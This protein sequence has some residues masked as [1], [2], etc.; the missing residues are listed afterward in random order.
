M[1][2]R[3]S[4]LRLLGRTPVRQ[5]GQR[6]HRGPATHVIILDGT[7]STLEP[8]CE[9]NAGLLYK[10]LDEIG[11]TAN[12]TVYYEAGLQWRNWG[13]TP[14]VAMGRGLNQQIR[15]AY[16]VLASRYREGDKII[17]AGYSRGAFAVRSLAGIIDTVGL[18]RDTDANV[19]NIRT[20]YQHYRQGG[21]S[22]AADAFRRRFCHWSVE[23]EAV[24]VWET[25]KALGVRLPI[26]WR[27]AEPAHAFHNHA[28]GR[29]IRHGFHALA[30]D[31]TREAY[32][33]V[34]WTARPGSTVEQVW[35]RGNHSDVGGQL[36]GRER[37]RPLSNIPLVWM[38]ER[39]ESCGV[40]LPEGWVARFPCDVTAPS[41]GSWT[42][43]GR[44]FLMR[45]KRLV[46]SDPSE[47]VHV[48][49][50]VDAPAA[51]VTGT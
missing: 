31:E 48:T 23:I 15:R 19:R 1:G 7:L 24:A 13:E 8:G 50:R 40:P 32:A 34:L 26:L 3:S 16:G 27:W 2:L 17:L 4:L 9:T 11:R 37:C 25:V 5:E 30:L 49:A 20:A 18:I 21:T 22:A 38:L 29:S 43:W 14:A 12:L 35:F 41:T 44:L 42:G 10:L 28:L 45:R 51:A 39:L 46:G 6:R 33:P 47:S 36:G